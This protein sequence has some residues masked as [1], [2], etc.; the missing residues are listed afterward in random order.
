MLSSNAGRGCLGKAIVR[1]HSSLGSSDVTP[2]LKCLSGRGNSVLFRL[3][4]GPPFLPPQDLLR[5]ALGGLPWWP[6]G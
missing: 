1:L 2:P 6:S 3:Y 4:L 5:L